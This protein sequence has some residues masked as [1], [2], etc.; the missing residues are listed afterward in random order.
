M[1][2][3]T[4]CMM[5][6]ASY[7]DSSGWNIDTHVPTY[8]QLSQKGPLR[9]DGWDRCFNW[10]FLPAMGVQAK[11][12]KGPTASWL[13]QHERT[14]WLSSTNITTLSTTLYQITG[15]AVGNVDFIKIIVLKAGKV[16]LAEPCSND[17][18]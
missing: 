8:L 5:D 9:F 1:Y 12:R 16:G 10:Q 13:N 3:L 2:A 15:N 6:W 14:C 11:A 18:N 17:K 7:G 4:N